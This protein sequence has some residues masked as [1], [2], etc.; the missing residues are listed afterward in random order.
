MRVHGD[1]RL[2]EGDV[3]HH[4]GGFAPDA[5]Q[6]LQRRALVRHLALMPLQQ[7]FAGG[8]YVLRLGAIQAYALDMCDQAV[9]AEGEHLLRRARHP[10]QAARGQIY[11]LVGRLGRQDH[12]DQEFERRAVFEFAA[13]LRI[14]PLQAL[15][16]FPAF[17][18]I[19][20]FFAA[21]RR[22]SMAAISAATRGG[23]LSMFLGTPPVFLALARSRAARITA[24]F[25]SG[26]GCPSFSCALRARRSVRSAVS[27]ARRALRN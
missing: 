20:R 24:F 6:L 11:A 15:K 18:R 25:A 1:G 5:G 9:H 10:V 7:Q 12:G 2:A 23:R 27:R 3:Q 19:H 26:M 17:G 22:A 4:A 14:R 16:D 13:R 21:R 8:E